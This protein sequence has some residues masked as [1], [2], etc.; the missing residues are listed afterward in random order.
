[1]FC[2]RAYDS[3][4]FIA[5]Y[6]FTVQLLNVAKTNTFI[7]RP[8]YIVL[9]LCLVVNISVFYLIRNDVN[10][11]AYVFKLPEDLRDYPQADTY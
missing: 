1:M 5:I 10:N 2:S 7:N 3:Q 9:K 8:K 11:L 6:I 4:L